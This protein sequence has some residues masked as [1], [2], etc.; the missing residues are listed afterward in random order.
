MTEKG[1]RPSA[2]KGVSP[3]RPEIEIGCPNGPCLGVL[4]SEQTDEGMFG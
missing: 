3:K 1:K 4:T 2:E